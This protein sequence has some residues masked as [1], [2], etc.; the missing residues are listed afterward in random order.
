M[1]KAI[2][3]TR[4][5][6]KKQ[7]LESQEDVLKASALA[8][9]FNETDIIY[10]GQQ[11]SGYNLEEDER[12]GL[13]ELY[14][15]IEQQ[16]ADTIYIW[17]ISRLA[18]KP[19]VQYSVRDILLENKVQLKCLKPQFTLLTPDRTHFDN[20]ANIIFSLFAALAEQEVIEKKERFARGKCRLAKEGKYSGGAIPFGYKVDKERENL[21]VINEEEAEIVREIYSLYET[22]LSQTAIAKEFYAR[23]MKRFTISFIHQIL[24]NKLTTGVKGQSKG[25]S[26][27]R[28]Y[29][30]IITTEQFDKCRNIADKNNVTI[31]KARNIY[32]A[33]RLIKCPQ[34]GAY[35]SSSGSKCLYRCYRANYTNKDYNGYDGITLCTNKTNISINIVDSLLWHVAQVIETEYVL[36][37]AQE[38]ID[39]LKGKKETLMT[40]SSN[41]KTQ[42]IDVNT[43]RERLREMYVDGMSKETYTKKKNIIDEEE[44]R[45]R[46]N[47]NEYKNEITHID[48]LIDNILSHY[49][50]TNDD[51]G[52]DIIT[53]NICD[54]MDSIES[55]EDDKIIYDIIHK[56]IK[57]IIIENS[58]TMYKFSKY[59]ELKETRAK[60]IT[61]RT[62]IGS[63]W[64][65][66]FIPF[67]GKGGTM[68]TCDSNFNIIHK[69]QMIYLKRFV[70]SKKKEK[71]QKEKEKQHKLKTKKLEERKSKGLLTLGEAAAVSKIGYATLWYAV[72]DGRL[73]STIVNNT[74]YLTTE[75]LTEFA[76][77]KRKLNPNT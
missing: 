9:G 34:C 58:T 71:R 30:Q 14:R 60:K 64:H 31:S 16:N 1:G 48:N 56:H 51:E 35:W 50:F 67:D 46:A 70:D 17:E 39:K 62:Y 54:I 38:D 22:G 12:K 5:S 45:I 33:N 23:G 8:D 11:E 73:H 63:D 13:E 26:Y 65:Y 59:K 61:I 18:R 57:E 66:C 20:T 24:T 40:K 25:A 77:N 15:L 42:F 7:H 6:T 3:F 55:V 74:K 49:S 69:E 28:S 44:K 4:I 36:N 41:I 2:I 19:K 76:K 72:K 47:E 68:L 52:A 29:P 53:N 37:S 27:E 10:I 75:E 32:Y 43:K 21:I